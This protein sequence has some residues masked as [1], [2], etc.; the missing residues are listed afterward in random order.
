MWRVPEQMFGDLASLCL[1]DTLLL[2]DDSAG[3]AGAMWHE[4]VG[5][6]PRE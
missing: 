6:I 2:V 3:M 5:S 4:C 1:Y